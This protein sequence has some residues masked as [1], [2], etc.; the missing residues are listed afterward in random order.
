M[1]RVG[2]KFTVRRRTTS[3]NLVKDA[4]LRNN[5]VGVVLLTLVHVCC[6]EKR[7]TQNTVK[8]A[9]VAALFG[10]SP[11][12]ACTSSCSYLMA[13]CNWSIFAHKE[14]VNEHGGEVSRTVIWSSG[15]ST[16]MA[17]F[18]ASAYMPALYKACA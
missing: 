2:Q 10:F 7:T 9:R 15:F 3:T 4:A 16:A 6:V 12:V 14:R 1:I 5:S 11:L 13:A 18:A 17:A 8:L